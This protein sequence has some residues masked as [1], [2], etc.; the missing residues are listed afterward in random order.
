MTTLTCTV[1]QIDRV[2]NPPTLD[3]SRLR[4]PASL[5]DTLQC[6]QDMHANSFLPLDELDRIPDLALTLCTG[7]DHLARH[8][9][10]DKAEA[11]LIA[12]LSFVSKMGKLP[13]LKHVVQP[14]AGEVDQQL[15]VAAEYFQV[16]WNAKPRRLFVTELGLLGLG[17]QKTEKENVVAVLFGCQWPVVLRPT[18]QEGHYTILETAYVHGIMFGE[19]VKRR[20]QEANENAVFHIH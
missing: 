19:A 16:V 14:E 3:S 1:G 4:P 20:Q 11:G 15:V 7:L 13:L 8:V 10:A 18:Q 5:V 2:H 6:L 9:T 12:L 17:P